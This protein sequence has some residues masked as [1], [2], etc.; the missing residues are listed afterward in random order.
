MPTSTD[1]KYALN[2]RETIRDEAVK[3]FVEEGLLVK[4]PDDP[5]RPTTSGKT[6]YQIERT[7]LRLCRTFMT[8]AWGDAIRRRD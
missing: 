7:A 2:T 5:S 3:H 4:N 1:L 8:A 6:V